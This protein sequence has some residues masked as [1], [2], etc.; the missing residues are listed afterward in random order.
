MI[1][2]IFPINHANASQIDCTGI[3]IDQKIYWDGVE[4]KPGQI[5]KLLI[6][7][8]TPLYKLVDGELV[9]DRILKKGSTYRIYNFRAEYLGVGGGYFVKRDERIDYRTPSKQ[10][11]NAVRCANPKLDPPAPPAPPPPPPPGNEGN[12]PPVVV[13]PEKPKLEPVDLGPQVSNL[14]TLASKAGVDNNGN[15]YLYIILHGTPSSLAVVDVNTNE[16]KSIFSLGNSTSAW[17]I[18][19]DQNGIVWV[20]GTSKGHLYSYNPNIPEFKD[21]GDMLAGTAETTIQDLSVTHQYVYGSTAYGAS[22]FAFNKFTGQ[23]EFIRSASFGKQFAKSILAE[24]DDSNL[25]VSTG[26]LAELFK[27]DVR[28]DKKTPLLSDVYKSESYA[29]KMKRID[30]DLIAVK[31][32]PSKRANLYS[33]SKGAFLQEFVADSR[34]FSPIEPEKNEFYYTF[35]GNFYAYHLGTGEI[36]NTNARLPRKRT[37]LSLDFIQ[38]KTNPSRNILTGLID[39]EG[40]YF[41]YNPFSNVVTVKKAILPSHPVNLHTLFA[42]PDNRF[43]YVNGFMTGGLTKFG[44]IEKKGVQLGGVNQLESAIV[45]NGKLYGGAYPKARLI[46]ITSNELWDQ[47]SVREM[48]ALDKYRQERITAMAGYNNTHLFAGTYAQD[49]L[50][51]G[52]LLNYNVATGDYKVYEDYITNQSIISLVQDDQYIYGGTSIHSNYQ[53]DQFSAKFF[54]FNS[55][56]PEEKEFFFLPVRATMVMS[57][58]KGPDGDIWGAADG[59]IFSYNPNLNKFRSVKLL[60]AISGRFSNA[61]LIAGK[62][63]FVYG[64]MEG[65]LFRINPADMSYTIMIESGAYEIAQDGMGNIYYRNLANLYMIPFER[66]HL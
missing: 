47:S 23:R 61:R 60:N 53:R 51:G 14:S 16:T 8:D 19:V 12:P 63:G 13:I 4:L 21:H 38:L 49:S 24:P 17:A 11:L 3:K 29:E 46:E 64:T 56:N 9:I 37:A 6:L 65:R 15:A 44:T 34:G 2:N 28:L 36:R 1:I 57:L 55:A 58:I 18:E 10:K 50:K 66:L 41:L 30:S 48:I 54:R 45:M 20:G 5:G 32:F 62:D 40:N 7:N 43:I 25:Y 42:D 35:D 39:N 52:L 27:W 26:P 22:V 59:T 31:F 33:L